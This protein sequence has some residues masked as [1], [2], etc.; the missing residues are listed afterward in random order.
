MSRV[1]RIALIGLA[2]WDRLLVVDRIAPIGGYAVVVSEASLPG[3]TT[4]NTAVAL[5]RL[6][7]KASFTGM[8]G[9]DADGTLLRAALAEAGVDLT[10]LSV[11]PNEPTDASTIIIGGDPPDRTIYWHK[12][13]H[14]VKGDRIDIGAVFDHDLVVL[15]VADAPLRR[16]LT[17][18]PAHT[19][20]RARLLG[21]LAYLVES[22]EPD[23]LEIALRCDTITGN[24]REA[25]LLTG[26][27]NL[28]DATAR[29]QAAMIGANLR[30]V[31]VSR[32]GNGCRAFTATEVW[33]IPAFAV[34]VVDTTG[35]GDA[36]TAG[37]AYGL[38]LRWPLPR[39]ATFGNAVGG[40]SIR[41]LGAQAALPGLDEALSL[42]R[43][44]DV[45]AASQP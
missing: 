15:D 20:P 29:L 27:T 43:T 22:G 34:D 38:A 44:A 11:R 4:T 17:D 7:A 24:E 32:G 13:A 25:L 14:I 40:L 31:L 28:D 1:P 2:S 36:F 42:V 39:A 26:D 19:A 37:L 6:G 33:D 12:G 10:G 9:D 23:E 30:S 45:S 18:L 3:G 16:F 21:T 41:K 5:A 8:I 35:A